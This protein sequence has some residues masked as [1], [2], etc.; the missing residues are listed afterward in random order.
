MA[1]PHAPAGYLMMAVVSVLTLITAA[2]H[3]W[4]GT[5]LFILN[6]IGYIGLLILLYVPIAALQPVQPIVRYVLIAYTTLTVL[7]Y[8]VPGPPYAAI[9][10][11]TKAVEVLLIVALVVEAVRARAVARRAVTD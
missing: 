3:L 10:L 11:G 9:G 2:I 1:S 7:L 6:G 8:L 4:L 5:P